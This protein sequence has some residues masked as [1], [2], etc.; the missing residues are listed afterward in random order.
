MV[1][2]EERN[3]EEQSDCGLTINLSKQQ[4]EDKLG[5]D[6]VFV[7]EHTIFGD[8]T[9]ISEAEAGSS[10]EKN[11]KLLNT[12]AIDDII[13]DEDYQRYKHL[14]SGMKFDSKEN[15]LFYF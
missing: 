14:P 12:S 4:L 9:G 2:Q 8:T 6:I 3:R 1:K 5:D 7:H 13:W 10:D 11:R 15:K